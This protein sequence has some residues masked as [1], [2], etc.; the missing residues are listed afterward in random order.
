MLSNRSR[1]RTFENSDAEEH[2][3]NAQSDILEY[4]YAESFFLRRSLKIKYEVSCLFFAFKFTIRKFTTIFHESDC[5]G[6]YVVPSMF[7]I[8]NKS[9]NITL[10]PNKNVAA[11]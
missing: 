3:P 5:N 6:L 1:L 2:M 11:A 7:F 4:V 10:L 9:V 8:W